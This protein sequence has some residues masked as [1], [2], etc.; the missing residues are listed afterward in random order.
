MT[1]PQTAALTCR[2]LVELLTA[3]LDDRL[4]AAE[5]ARVD[6]H[7]A[8]CEGCTHYLQQLRLTIAR[9]GQLREEH[10]PPVMR[11]RLL[12]AF[13]TWKARR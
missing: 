7:L 3:Y 13:R 2:E 6:Q 12:A 1:G 11:S 4:P 5:R 9:V 8:S 10:L